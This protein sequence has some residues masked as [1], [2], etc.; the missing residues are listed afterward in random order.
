M[1]PPDASREHLRR[2]RVPD[3]WEVVV[4]TAGPDVLD[5]TLRRRASLATVQARRRLTQ[6]AL[7][8]ALLVVLA[9]VPW[10][11]QL[12]LPSAWPAREWLAAAA[13]LLWR[14]VIAVAVAAV[15][16]PH[17]VLSESISVMRGLGVQL[18]T[19]RGSG[20][21]ATVFVPAEEV[22]S[23]VV[24]EGIAM[25]DVHYYLALVV[26]VG[27]KPSLLLPFPTSRPRLPVLGRIYKL[28]NAA[29]DGPGAAAAAAAAATA[30][31]A[32]GTAPLA[33]A[34]PEAVTATT[35]PAAAASVP[36]ER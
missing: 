16:V 7:A 8:I 1:Q 12:A 6:A 13:D 30:T 3:V 33:A 14:A 17:P 21:P 22:R 11:L 10:R 27:R 20:R 23:A 25:C 34:G 9:L 5:V 35:H 36:A 32:V 29:L 19:W 26:G 2:H 31:A 28:L 18:T 4:A 24:N 15:A